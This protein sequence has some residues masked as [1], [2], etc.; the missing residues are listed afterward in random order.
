MKKKKEEMSFVV[1][2]CSGVSDHYTYKIFK[3]PQENKLVVQSLAFVTE[4]VS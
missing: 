1:G 3:V 4:T 2:I